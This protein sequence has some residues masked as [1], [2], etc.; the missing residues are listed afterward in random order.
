[1]SKPL[2][3][4]IVTFREGNMFVAQ[5]LEVDVAAQGRTSEQAVANLRATIR[6]EDAEAV[7]AGRS[8]LDIGPAPHAYHVMFDDNE[9]DRLTTKVA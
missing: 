9:I 5:A 8:I 2:N 3:I 1:M 7:A 4:R 6:D